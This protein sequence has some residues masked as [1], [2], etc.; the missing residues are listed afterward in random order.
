[1]QRRIPDM[2]L[3]MKRI[4]GCNQTQAE[5]EQNVVYSNSQVMSICSAT[6]ELKIWMYDRPWDSGPCSSPTASG[7][8]SGCPAH[9]YNVSGSPRNICN[10]PCQLPTAKVSGEVS[11]KLQVSCLKANKLLCLVGER[12]NE[13]MGVQEGRAWVKEDA[14]RFTSGHCIVSTEGNGKGEQVEGKLP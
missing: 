2:I 12:A 13:Y 11:R 4:S 10:L 5:N 7:L 3:W 1:M 8:W 6:A 14:W 9:D